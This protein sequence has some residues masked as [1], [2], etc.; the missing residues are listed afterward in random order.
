MV[1]KLLKLS[2]ELNEKRVL[3]MSVVIRL[4]RGGR[5]NLPVY[6]IVVADSR[7]AATG[8]FI[9]RL[10]HFHPNAKGESQG[11][12]L[13]EARL[14]EWVGKGAQVSEAVTRLLIKH[15]IGPAKVKADFQAY[16]ARRI[17]AQQYTADQKAKGEAAKAAKEA[18]ANAPAEAPVAEAPVEAAPAAAAETPAA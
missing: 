18:A 6:T 14:T 1:G 16:K 10:G 7:R 8:K 15:N 12:V 2:R 5:T 3:N 9:E 11:F 4:S 17:K 13:N